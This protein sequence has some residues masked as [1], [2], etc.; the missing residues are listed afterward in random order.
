MLCQCS[1][2]TMPVLGR[3]IVSIDHRYLTQLGTHE[4]APRSLDTHHLLILCLILASHSATNTFRV[5]I[6]LPMCLCKL[7]LQKVRHRT[8]PGSSIFAKLV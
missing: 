5:A 1:G 8:E 6:H 4:N 7:P 2:V 3:S